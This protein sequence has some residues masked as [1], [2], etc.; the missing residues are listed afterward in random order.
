M[1]RYQDEIDGNMLEASRLT[2]NAALV[3]SLGLTPYKDGNM[4]CYS[5]GVNLQEGIAGFGITVYEAAS[6][7]ETNYCNESIQIIKR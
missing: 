7:F 1:S 2:R 3:S 6:D 5:Y 4:W